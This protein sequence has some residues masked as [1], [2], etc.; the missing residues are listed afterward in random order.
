MADKFPKYLDLVIALAFVGL[1]TSLVLKPWSPS[2]TILCL[3]AGINGFS[4]GF[5]HCKSV[6][7]F[8]ENVNLLYYFQLYEVFVAC[9]NSLS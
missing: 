7:H 5:Y 6:S 4:G 1:G 3:L 8:K 9:L 2:I